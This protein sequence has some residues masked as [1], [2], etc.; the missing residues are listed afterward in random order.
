VGDFG[1]LPCVE[2]ALERGMVSKGDG[3]N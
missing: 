3:G 1:Y 2:C